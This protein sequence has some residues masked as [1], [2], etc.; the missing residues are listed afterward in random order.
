MNKIFSFSGL[1]SIFEDARADFSA[2]F[3][4]ARAVRGLPSGNYRL[5]I[6]SCAFAGTQGKEHISFRLEVTHGPFSGRRLNHS[7]YV[8][9]VNPQQRR[10]ELTRLRTLQDASGLG[11]ERLLNTEIFVG[12]EFGGGLWRHVCEGEPE[13]DLVRF[14]RTD[15]SWPGHPAVPSCSRTITHP[16]PSHSFC[17]RASRMAAPHRTGQFSGIFASDNVQ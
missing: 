3:R 4:A 6:I 15:F 2:N 16:S 14:Y 17:R 7:I 11:R 5:R 1:G 8:F 13:I 9:S 12:R 10:R